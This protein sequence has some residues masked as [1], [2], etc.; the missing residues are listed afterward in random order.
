MQSE[1]VLELER[2]KGLAKLLEWEMETGRARE[3]V[4]AREMERA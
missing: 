1:R 3:S 2:A 4:I